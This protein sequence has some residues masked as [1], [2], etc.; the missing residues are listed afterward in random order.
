MGAYLIGVLLFALGIAVTI[1]LHEAGHMLT[2]RAFGMR[3]RRFFIGFGPKVWSVKRGHTEYGV[4][5][6]PFGG[7]CEIAGM[8]ALDEVTEEEAPHA[9]R[10]KPAWQRIL[11]LSGGVIVNFALGLSIIYGVAVA[12][13]IPDPDKTPVV[14]ET[15]CS[16]DQNPDG[17]LAECMGVGPAAEAG[18][19][20]G[21][22]ILSL[23]GERLTDFLDLRDEVMARP[24]ETVVLG[25]ERDGVVL[26]VPVTLETVTRYTES[27]EAIEAGSVGLQSASPVRTF[28]PLEAVPAT[29]AYTGDM[30]QAT[31]RGVVELPLKIPSVA[32]AIFGAE[33]DP[34]GPMSVVGA[35]RVGGEL[36]EAKLWPAFFMMLASL[37]FFLGLFNL[38][39]LPPLDGGH[40]AVVIYE[41]IRD[42]FRRLR[43][44]APGGPV[45]YERLMP[46]TMTMVFI[47]VTVGGLVLVA[48]VV[49]PI[50][51][52]GG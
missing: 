12:S 37:N 5:A 45:N 20:P 4:A 13:G 1:A 23:D 46:V 52:F 21:D 25:V 48:D 30:L 39:P 11:V 18:V 41:K 19:K 14:G 36:V 22:R 29:F 15:V 2:A 38:V 47:L 10:A 31:V 33:R 24:G 32:A 42:F 43:G 6:V 49:N 26:D 27:G 3:V 9:M 51:L 7:F 17:T 50:R 35:S 34:E 44:L 40:I 16:A 8:T 28:G